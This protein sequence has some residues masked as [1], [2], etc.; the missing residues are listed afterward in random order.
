MSTKAILITGAQKRLGF[1]LAQAGLDMG[2]TVIIH[3]HKPLP[4][5]EKMHLFQE[6]FRDKVFFVQHELSDH[7]EKLFDKIAAF[8]LELKGL[9]NNASVFSE[10]NISDFTHFESLFRVNFEAPLKLA[11]RFSEIVNAG[12]IIN[13]TDSNNR[14]FNKRFQNYRLIKLFLEELTFQQASLYAPDIRVNGI[15]PGAILPSSKTEE[16]FFRS[17]EKKIP[18]N[19]TKQ[20]QSL[21]NA[22]KFLAE[23]PFVTGE[24]IHVDGGW[25]LVA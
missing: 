13:I 23:S 17:L 7:P 24:I 3:H 15:A 10:G 22:F 20:I 14:K 12:W 1:H 11:Q 19:M 9:V 16:D 21:T 5:T 18:L 6:Q 25:N 2:Y 8:Q 4:E